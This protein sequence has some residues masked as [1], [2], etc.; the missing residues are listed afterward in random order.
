LRDDSEE[1][2]DAVSAPGYGVTIGLSYV[3][4]RK[5]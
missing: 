2:D 3:L 1:I 5:S 4:W